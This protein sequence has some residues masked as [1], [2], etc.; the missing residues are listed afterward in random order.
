MDWWPKLLRCTG[1]KRAIARHTYRFVRRYA[2][3][4]GPLG[5]FLALGNVATLSLPK[6]RN[7]RR[8]FLST[9]ECLDPQ[10]QPAFRIDSRFKGYFT[11]VQLTDSNGELN[12]ELSEVMRL[13]RPSQVSVEFQKAIRPPV[14]RPDLF[15]NEEV[16]TLV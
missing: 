14:E 12:P 16:Q 7:P 5:T 6:Y 13:K 1:R 10:Y 11:P 8:T 15:L 3:S 9:S 4:L 2:T